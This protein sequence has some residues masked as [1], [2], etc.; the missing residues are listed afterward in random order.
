MNRHEKS[1]QYALDKL[2][3]SDYSDYISCVYLYGS[4]SRE[5]YKFNSD[6]DLFV[7]VHENTPAAILRKMR[8]DVIND[9]YTLPE[10]EL[11][12]SKSG[13]YS[14]SRQFNENLQKE[15]VLLWENQ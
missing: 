12:V 7:C 6:I 14:V 3:N 5:D 10:V 8:S 15:A 11:M 2:K 9:D 1:L 4:C 13:L